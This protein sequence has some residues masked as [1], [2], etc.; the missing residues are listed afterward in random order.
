MRRDPKRIA[1]LF[2]PLLSFALLWSCATSSGEGYGKATA[3]ENG[4]SAG[5]RP[6]RPNYQPTGTP[7]TKG[8]QIVTDPDNAEVYLNGAFQGRTPLVIKDLG[9]G[10]YRL[11]LRKVG[12][13]EVTSWIDFPGDFMLF[14]TPLTRITGFIRLAVSPQNAEAMLGGK[15]V[16]PGLLEIPVGTYRLL[17]R[18]FGFSEYSESIEVS[19]KD[20]KD[21][22]VSL[23]PVL[24]SF[25]R[26][27]V[28]KK[29]VNPDNPGILGA[30]E[31][32]FSVSGPGTGELSIFNS[33][34]RM[35]FHDTL[36]AFSAWNYRYV[37]LPKDSSG[38]DL[39]DGDYRVLFSGTGENSGNRDEKETALRID[40]GLREAPRSLW[41]GS[42]GL[43]YAPTSE[44]LPDASYQLSFLG[45]AGSSDSDFQAP[46]QFSA[47]FGLGDLLEIDGV[48]ATILSGSTPFSLGVAARYPL[49]KAAPRYG[50]GMAVEAKAAFQLNPTVG[51]LTTDVFSNFSGLSVGFPLSFTLGPVSLLAD[52]SAIASLWRPFDDSTPPDSA[53][54]S[55]LYLRG[56][57]LLDLG[58]FSGGISFSA[59]T[60]PF[61]D[62][63]FSFSEPFQ[64]GLEAHWLIPGT[65]LVFTGA[66]LVDF[67][68]IS[69]ASVMCGG[70]LGFIY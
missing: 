32:G 34:S 62:G 68:G 48:A 26:I 46:V 42:A 39:P 30:V 55:W 59:R 70:G 17:V 7:V 61:A 44:I 12:Y 31:M 47:R 19:Q 9:K 27:Q 16:F 36:T 10:S 67:E 5:T 13:E 20:V 25:T 22:D 63:A 41:S 4:E 56:G 2:T 40:R 43:L 54:V 23:T 53:L 57:L 37:W 58:E 6:V 18:A 38:G 33:D 29:T 28:G 45:V 11:Q 65:H 8:L 52:I 49:V 69:D 24:F 15:R 66:L 3:I 21:I 60:R 14:Q 1:L 50:F 64:T 51:V 35:V